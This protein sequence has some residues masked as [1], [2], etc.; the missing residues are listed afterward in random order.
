[1]QREHWPRTQL[2]LRMVGNLD[3]WRLIIT[4]PLAGAMNMALDEALLTSVTQGNSPPI[5]RFYRWSPPAIT[6]GYF[7]SLEKEVNLKACQKAGVDVV[8]RLTGGRAVLHQHEL[9]YSLIAPENHQKVA[10]S[11]LDSYLAISRGLVQGLAKIGVEAELAEGKKNT[12]TASAAC[13]DAPSWYEMVV[14]GRKLV[15]SAQTRR[16]GCIL[17]HG[18]LLCDLDADLLFSILNFSSEKVRE[19]AKSVLLSKATTLKEIL[20]F[21][22]EFHWLCDGLKKGFEEALEIN[23]SE[24]QLSIGE[25]TLARELSINKYRTHEWNG[26]R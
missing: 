9:T 4:D 1:M 26:R 3:N 24:Q 21:S 18:S 2:H 22:P 20:G 14:N 10:G 15:G 16:S 7:Q 8:R 6:L 5:I 13:F 19:R 25:I 23:L 11:I 17:Q 12:G